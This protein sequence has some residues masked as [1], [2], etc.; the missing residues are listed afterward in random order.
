MLRPY[1]NVLNSLERKQPYKVALGSLEAARAS[2]GA[3]EKELGASEQKDSAERSGSKS[4]Q[5]EAIRLRG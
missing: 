1:L 3:P 5:R 2:G 4:K